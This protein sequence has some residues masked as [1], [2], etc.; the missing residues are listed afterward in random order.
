MRQ[1]LLFLSLIVAMVCKAQT[2]QELLPVGTMAPDLQ[3]QIA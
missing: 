1:F 2:K 3:L